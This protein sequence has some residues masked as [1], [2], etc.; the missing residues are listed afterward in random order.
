MFAGV[1]AVISGT[2]QAV[3]ASKLKDL[4]MSNGGTAIV[5]KVTAPIFA[6]KIEPMDAKTTH[7]LVSSRDV[8]VDVVKKQLGI[9]QVP[10]SMKIIDAAWISDSIVKSAI[11]PEEEYIISN[12]MSAPSTASSLISSTDL[13]NSD[14]I[15]GAV[16]VGG[17]RRRDDTENTEGTLPIKKNR[18]VSS[19]SDWQTISSSGTNSEKPCVM[20]KISGDACDFSEMIAFDLDGTL[21][22]TKS[23]KTFGENKNDWKFLYDDIPSALRELYS[24]GK[25]LAI[26]SNQNGIGKPQGLSM[27]DLQ[28]KL[29]SILSH[30]DFPID[31]ICAFEK[32]I[33]RKPRIGAWEYLINRRVRNQPAL[34]FTYVGDAA[35]RPKHGLRPKDFSASDLKFALN[36]GGNVGHEYLLLKC[37]MFETFSFIHRSN[38]LGVPKMP[39]IAISLQRH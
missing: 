35:G 23:G 9:T 22:Q 26:I 24:Q 4:I 33:F 2:V 38:S 11:Q 21:I 3:R 39:S 10:V 12:N 7:I 1:N 31:V 14:S 19:T 8:S 28:F 15:F 6:K 30:F 34:V 16:S 27:I 32:D 29:D 5:K 13:T 36:T 18:L 17:K 25:Y 37:I 20:Y